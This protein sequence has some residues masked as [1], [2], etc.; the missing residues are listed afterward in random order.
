MET[1]GANVNNAGEN[2]LRERFQAALEP[3]RPGFQADGMDLVV[4][5]VDVPTVEVRVRMGPNACQE[6][7]LPPETLEKF[8]L[9]AIRNVDAGVERVEVMIDRS[10][11]GAGDN[12]S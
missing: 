4:G 5:S 10:A 9:A 7:L 2:A 8:F 1:T 11:T 6:C 12:K 3:L